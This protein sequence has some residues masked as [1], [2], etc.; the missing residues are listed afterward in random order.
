MQNL[1]LYFDLMAF[2]FTVVC[3]DDD[4][5]MEVGVQDVPTTNTLSDSVAWISM[6]RSAK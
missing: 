5:L 3:Y 6:Y 4:K 2:I 1:I